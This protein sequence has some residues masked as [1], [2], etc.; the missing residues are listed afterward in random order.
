M[1]QRLGIKVWLL[2]IFASIAVGAGTG[3][4]VGFWD[5]KKTSPS[6]QSSSTTSQSPGR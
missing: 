4:G 5:L 2:I 3:A 1:D 6:A